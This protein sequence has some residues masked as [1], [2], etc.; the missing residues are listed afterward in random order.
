M[1]EF[2]DGAVG[3][4]THV[5]APMRERVTP[6]PERMAELKKQ[7]KQ[8]PSSGRSVQVESVYQ[9]LSYQRPPGHLTPCRG[10]RG[11][12]TGAACQAVSS[13]PYSCLCAASESGTPVHVGVGGAWEW[14]WCIYQHPTAHDALAQGKG[15]SSEVSTPAH[16][17]W[18]LLA[19]RATRTCLPGL[20]SARSGSMYHPAGGEESQPEDLA[21]VNSPHLELALQILSFTV[22]IGSRRK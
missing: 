17:E 5:M 12:H 22:I 1:V 11:L 4:H 18:G 21:F 2:I 9:A 8:P 15:W 7:S 16:T 19:H 3:D 14:P 20:P 6:G 13:V 10:H